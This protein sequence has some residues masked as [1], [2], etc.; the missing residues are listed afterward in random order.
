M[1]RRFACLVVILALLLQ[2]RA[3]AAPETEPYRLGYGDVLSISSVTPTEPTAS[4]GVPA[5]AVRP[6][7]RIALPL[8]GEVSVGGL[9]PTEV[10]NQ[11]AERY[12]SYYG[13][14]RFIVNVVKFR[15]HSIAVT[16]EVR[17]GGSFA[18]ERAPT[19]LEAIAQA[20]GLEDWAITQEVMILRDGRPYKRLDLERVWSGGEPDLRLA[21]RDVVR[22]PGAWYK[23]LL[24]NVPA[25]TSFAAS[26]VTLAVVLI[27][28]R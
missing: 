13:N 16:G 4:Q 1:P 5:V 10:A 17:R 20:G 12:R 25:L 6:D 19:V 21:D 24:Q 3:S 2:P 14:A 9:S 23:P 28:G 26:A 11:L 15:P 8:I 22:V 7:G 18:F 27:R